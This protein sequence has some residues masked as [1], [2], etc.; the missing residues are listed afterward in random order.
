MQIDARTKAILSSMDIDGFKTVITE[1]LTRPEYVRVNEVLETL[2]GKWSRK[3][4]AHVWTCSPSEALKVVLGTDSTTITTTFETKKEQK[5][6][7]QVFHTPP[8]LAD[9]LVEVACICEFNDD[10]I[11][12]PS[13]GMGSIVQAVNRVVSEMEVDC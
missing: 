3:D 12:E 9:R 4:K 2:G 7:Y 10:T 11:L 13:A 5:K 1:T 6:T 8:E